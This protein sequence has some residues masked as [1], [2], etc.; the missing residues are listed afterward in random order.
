MSIELPQ[1]KKVGDE[2]ENVKENIN[3]THLKIS[4][5]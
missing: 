3:G 1:D 2:K 4:I 5:T